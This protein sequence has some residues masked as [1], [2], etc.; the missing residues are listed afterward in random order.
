MPKTRALTIR[1]PTWLYLN[2]KVT[3]E[4]EGNQVADVVRRILAKEL[5]KQERLPVPPPRSAVG[6]ERSA[7]EDNQS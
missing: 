1:L 2:V 3:A 5:P 4:A 7:Q 6:R